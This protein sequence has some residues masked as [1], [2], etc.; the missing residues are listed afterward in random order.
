MQ[1]PNIKSLRKDFI[2]HEENIQ[3]FFGLGFTNDSTETK[4]RLLLAKRDKEY[5]LTE[6]RTII[7]KIVF[8]IFYFKEFEGDTFIEIAE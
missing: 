5:L 4:L 3:H 2:I 8:E 1:I 6:L 7:S